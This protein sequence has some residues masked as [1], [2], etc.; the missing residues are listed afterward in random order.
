MVEVIICLKLLDKQEI[1][2]MMHIKIYKQKKIINLIIIN[3][4]LMIDYQGWQIMLVIIVH[5]HLINLNLILIQIH[6]KIVVLEIV[7]KV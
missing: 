7:I 6:I 2:I 1:Q 4:D 5:Q 3:K